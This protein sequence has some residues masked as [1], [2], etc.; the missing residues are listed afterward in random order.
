MNP[1]P[2]GGIYILSAPSGAGKTSLTRALVQGEPKIAISV[3]HTTRGPRP[4]EVDGTHYHFVTPAVF[5]HMV[6]SGAFVEHAKV[7]GNYY[8]TARATLDDLRHQGRHVLL[9]I[10][11]QGARRIKSLLP[12]AVSIYILPPSLAS[13]R[14][15]LLGRGQDPV[16]VIERRMQEALAEISH[17]GEF[18]HVIVNDDFEDALADL[19]ALLA[20]GRDR[21]PELGKQTLDRWLQAVTGPH[22][23]VTPG[24][25]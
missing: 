9:D 8:G 5:Q 7:F 17:A 13:L 15:R 23:G 19:R 20:S 21:R 22:H 24:V 11:W 18:D 1:A 2:V 14:A 10:D 25:E 4:G 12:E 16:P 3:S 6:A